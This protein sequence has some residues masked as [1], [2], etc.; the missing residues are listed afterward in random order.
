M[1]ISRSLTAMLL[2]TG[3]VLEASVSAQQPARDAARAIRMPIA[4]T[5]QA[6]PPDAAF[7][8]VQGNALTAMDEPLANVRVRLRDVLYGRDVASQLT[9][10]SG[11]FSFRRVDPGTYT[12]ELLEAERR[13]V[14]ASDLVAV[15]A[16]DSASTVVRLPQPARRLG[17]ASYQLLAILSAA[18]AAGVL[19]VKPT[20]EDI[21][22]R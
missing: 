16:G 18:A 7:A 14:A 17:A 4:A 6:G 10:P 15:N 13:V 20:G 11:R 12:V 8:T 9:D 5:S 22:P 3:L 2:I 19:A 1:T 21:S